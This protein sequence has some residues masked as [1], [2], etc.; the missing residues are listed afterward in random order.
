MQL[1][2]PGDGSSAGRPRVLAW[3]A[4]RK[5]RANPHAALLARELIRLGVDLSDWTPLGAL[6]RPGDLWHLHHPDSVLNRRHTAASMMETFAFLG[7]LILAQARGVQVLWTIHDLGS[8]DAL[9]PRVEAWFWKVFAPRVDAVVCLSEHSRAMALERFPAL[10]TRPAHVVPHGHYEDAYPNPATLET[11]RQRLDI[12]PSATV[13]LNLGL[14]RPYKN[15]PHLIRTFR[16]IAG[17][18]HVLI[19]AGRSFDAAVE[20]AIRAAAHGADN[21]R[22]D[23][24][25]IPP[26]EVS[27][28]FA[29][30]DLSFYP[31]AKS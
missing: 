18:D 7:L 15:I 28:H 6:L 5:Q 20:R 30:A 14:M 19:I 24:R 27:D 25:W 3:P 22:L 11:A 2:G 16:S 1:F 17:A 26:E 10:R 13:L 31:T 29:A 9:H 23:L 4:F 12:A 21:V 8:N